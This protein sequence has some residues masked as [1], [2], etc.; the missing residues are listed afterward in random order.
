MTRNYL[1]GFGFA[2]LG[3]AVSPGCGG[4]C[5]D[6]GWVWNQAGNQACAPAADG[7]ATETG[8]GTTEVATDGPGTQTTPTTTDEDPTM[9]SATMGGGLHCMDADGDGFGDP[10]MCQDAPF[11]GS[12]PNDGDCDDGD[13]FTF[14]GAAEN[15]SDTACMK[16]GDEDGWGDDMPGPGVEP[17]TDC[18]DGNGFAFPGAA[19]NESDTACMEDADGDGWGDNMPGPGV[20]PG[21]DCNDDAA[22]I[23]PG[24]A[25]NES[26]TA[27]MDDADGD[28]WGSSTPGPGAEP[29]T[30]CDDN[31]A[32]TFP[33]AA[34]N[35]SPESCMKDED[36]DDYGDDF[37]GGEPPPGVVPGTDCNDGDVEVWVTCE[38]CNPNEDACVDSNLIKCSGNGNV[39]S[40]EF[41]EFGC[42]EVALQCLEKLE[43]D[44]GETVCIDAGQS[45]QLMATA[46]GGDGSY[47]YDWTPAG[48]LDD[49]TIA[50]PLASPVGPT[51]YTVNVTDGQ[52]SMASDSVSVYI[53][54]LSLN[55]DPQ[56]CTT[57]DFGGPTETDPP[58][59]WAWNANTKTL[60]QT[61]NGRASALFC[62]WELNDA[63]ITGTFSVNTIDDD[64][65]TGFIWG[66]QDTDH[67]YLFT[68]KQLGQNFPG[69]GGALP[70]GMQVKVIDV[71]NP[72]ANPL[73]CADRHQPADTVN[74]KLL[75]PT[76]EFTQQGWLDNVQY[77]FELTHKASGEIT[78]VV[79]NKL[80]NI[81]IA[82]KTFMDQTYPSGKFGMY[83]KSQVSACF[84]DYK[85][86]CIQ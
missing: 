59:N 29:G 63:K 36:D 9:G 74:S 16:D 23:F 39:I 34:P 28:G 21:T 72:V 20:D 65:W 73:T 37:G 70:A 51:T 22:S 49:A 60:C 76:S 69:C 47:T 5:G 2:A 7:S 24:A 8:P 58:T 25:E 52:G 44:A 57:Y 12:V 1:L 50:G 4:V 3:L 54:N 19:E 32:G 41:C 13:G 15:E 64:D 82:E 30:D 42:D 66:L 40:K 55:L 84:S 75:V 33:G 67:F 83:T 77:L 71:K 10:E 6:D 48:T 68:W 31:S 56:I 80:T 14:P 86:F 38:P 61:I 81:I 18:D 78:I 79:R 11:P 26:D 45:T 35:D 27:C 43:V 85:T 53:N 62:G 17:G 46:M